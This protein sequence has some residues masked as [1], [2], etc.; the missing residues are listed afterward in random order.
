M[1]KS[2]TNI[3]ID[4]NKISPEFS[5]SNLDDYKVHNLFSE[6]CTINGLDEELFLTLKIQKNIKELKYRQ[7][8]CLRLSIFPTSDQKEV[9]TLSPEKWSD[10]IEPTEIAFKIFHVLFDK[11]GETALM[12]THTKVKDDEKYR[13]KGVGSSLFA[14]SEK[15][16]KY[17]MTLFPD[18]TK[19]TLTSIDSRED[20]WTKRRA[21][22]QGY[23]DD[24]DNNKIYE[25][26]ILK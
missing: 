9:S 16:A 2:E 11:K 4:Q 19:I 21:K 22:E 20:Q 25:K 13:K 23:E 7:N 5:L 8:Y 10:F 12:V 26:V 14:L 6:P 15:I 17:T 18:L 3:N 24:V 1:S